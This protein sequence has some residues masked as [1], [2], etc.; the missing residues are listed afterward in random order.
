MRLTALIDPFGNMS[1]YY[2]DTLI[3]PFF[4]QPS[5]HPPTHPPANL[6]SSSVIYT[7]ISYHTHTHTLHI[8]L[9][10]QHHRVHQQPSSA[11]S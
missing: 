1:W 6:L 8:T 9:S 3:Y 4:S 5:V 7:Y 2:L 10:I 11:D